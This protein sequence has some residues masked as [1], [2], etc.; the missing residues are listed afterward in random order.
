MLNVN[1]FIQRNPNWSADNQDVP[2]SL[3]DWQGLKKFIRKQNDLMDS[4]EEERE[5]FY[6][7]IGR[8]YKLVLSYCSDK[9]E[10]WFKKNCKRFC[11]QYKKPEPEF[12]GWL[13]E[14]EI[15]QFKN[16]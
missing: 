4:N 7:T 1:L 15:E 5:K 12:K 14:E 16:A 2:K 9:E 11:K 8:F 6:I 3:F 10:K 13:T